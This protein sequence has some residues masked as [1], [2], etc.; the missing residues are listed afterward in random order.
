MGQVSPIADTRAPFGPPGSTSPEA[1]RPGTGYGKGRPLTMQYQSPKDGPMGSP[2]T[3][4]TNTPPTGYPNGGPNGVDYMHHDPNYPHLQGQRPPH[5][6]PGPQR[7]SI[8]TNVGPYG[9]LSPVSTQH[10]YQSQPTNTPQSSAAMPYV[11]PQNFPPFTLPPSDFSVA[12]PATVGREASQSYVPPA[13]GEADTTGIW[14]RQHPQQV[15]V[16]RDARRFYGIP[17]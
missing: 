4:M 13:P 5:Q 3:P 8:Q 9:V 12:S 17:L 1:N 7:P 16:R 2:Y 6:S 14:E 10:G 11:P 15:P